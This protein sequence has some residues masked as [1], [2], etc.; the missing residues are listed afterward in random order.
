[1]EKNV[2]N[3]CMNGNQLTSVMAVSK[4][5]AEERRKLV[6]V[7]TDR[8]DSLLNRHGLIRCRVSADGNCMFAAVAGQLMNTTPQNIRN[9]VCE[10]FYVNCHHYINYLRIGHYATNTERVENYY[11]QVNAL[12]TTAKWDINIADAIP[13]ALANIYNRRILVF[14]S[15]PERPLISV[16]PDLTKS[17]NEADDMPLKLAHIGIE[18]EEHY[19]DCVLKNAEEIPQKPSAL[20]SH[21]E[22]DKNQTET[23]CNKVAQNTL[24][25]TAVKCKN[26]SQHKYSS[27]TLLQNECQL[28]TP[29]KRKCNTGNAD[30][31]IFQSR[32]MK[33]LLHKKQEHNYDDCVTVFFFFFVLN[34]ICIN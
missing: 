12:R 30:L 10:H 11:K 18:G 20:I 2:K 1:M 9:L 25:E 8:L 4:H 17:I 7:H 19:D 26:E 21:I 16:E 5:E 29:L 23:A 3:L 34:L 13:L 15:L 32:I 31:V 27:S 6:T 33:S 24:K 14:S 28:N 22:P